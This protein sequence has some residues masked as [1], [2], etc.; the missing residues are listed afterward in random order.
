[1]FQVV[2]GHWWKKWEWGKNKSLINVPILINFQENKY[3]IN[4]SIGINKKLL[5]QKWQYILKEKL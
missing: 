3:E 1:M 4:I 5:V 2:R